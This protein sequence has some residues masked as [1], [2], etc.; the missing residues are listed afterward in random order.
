VRFFAHLVLAD[1][2]TIL[3]PL[4]T[5]RGRNDDQGSEKLGVTVQVVTKGNAKS[6]ECNEDSELDAQELVLIST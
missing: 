4:L 1:L 3:L 6:C 5:N 2:T